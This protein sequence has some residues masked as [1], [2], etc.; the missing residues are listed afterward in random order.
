MK[1]RG[2]GIGKGT[3]IRV[4]DWRETESEDETEAV[5]LGKGLR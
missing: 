5:G 3:E 2:S 1:Q 4:G